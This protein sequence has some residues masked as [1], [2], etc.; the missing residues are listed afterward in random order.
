MI[1][2]LIL[3]AVCVLALVSLASAAATTGDVTVQSATGEVITGAGGTNV[4]AETNVHSVEVQDGGHTDDITVQGLN[5][6]TATIGVG[7]NVNSESNVGSV[8]VGN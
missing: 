8:K 6:G 5:V 7:S 4:N 1:R 2:H 3:T